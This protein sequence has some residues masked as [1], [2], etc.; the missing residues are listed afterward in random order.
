MTSSS[1]SDDSA[2]YV[3]LLTSDGAG[4]TGFPATLLPNAQVL[5]RNLPVEHLTGIGSGEIII[6]P[7]P[8]SDLPVQRVRA[9]G[10]LAQLTNENSPTAFAVITL[11]RPVADVPLPDSASTREALEALRDRFDGDL[12]AGLQA[13]GMTATLLPVDA[14]R[15]ASTARVVCTEPLVRVGPLRDFSLCDILPVHCG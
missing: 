4:L 1:S 2:P 5:V 9:T 8:N 13:E 10:T 11:S 3:M 6:I 7:S 14:Q 15:V 12:A